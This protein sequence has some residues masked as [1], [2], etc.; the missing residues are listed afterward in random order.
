MVFPSGHNFIP[1]KYRELAKLHSFLAKEKL[2][3]STEAL[4]IGTS[5]N[6]T[7]ELWAVGSGFWGNAMEYY[8]IFH[9]LA[10]RSST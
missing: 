7:I 2:E 3:V 5:C 9:P 10:W 1:W 8:D 4:L 6:P